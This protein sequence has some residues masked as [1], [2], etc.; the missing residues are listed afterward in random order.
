MLCT[1]TGRNLRAIEK[2]WHELQLEP[3][4]SQYMKLTDVLFIGTILCS[5]V[6]KLLPCPNS[7]HLSEVTV[8]YVPKVVNA[9]LES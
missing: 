1:G 9:Q 7:L 8:R 5:Y 4:N 2:Q 6:L 3:G